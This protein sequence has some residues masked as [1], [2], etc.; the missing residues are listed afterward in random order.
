MIYEIMMKY[1]KRCIEE[2]LIKKNIQIKYG[3][4]MRIKI[5]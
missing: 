2:D 4:L 1:E 5:A 3:I